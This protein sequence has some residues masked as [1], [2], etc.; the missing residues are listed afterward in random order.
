MRLRAVVHLGLGP[1]NKPAVP[2]LVKALRDDDK[3]VRAAAVEALPEIGCDAEDAAVRVAAARALWEVDQS[4][5][6]LVVLVS[7]L[8]D[9]DDKIC[10]DAAAMLERIGPGAKAIVPDLLRLLKDKYAPYYDPAAEA[11]KKIDPEAAKEAGVP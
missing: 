6:A 1:F 3:I 2:A 4:K 8:E 5:D 7:A 11:L 9:K 10:C